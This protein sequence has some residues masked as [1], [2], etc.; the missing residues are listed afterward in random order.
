MYLERFDYQDRV[1]G[2]CHPWRTQSDPML[3]L[4]AYFSVVAQN[5]RMP[6]SSALRGM[7]V[8][9]QGKQHHFQI[10]YIS[11]SNEAA[12]SLKRAWELTRVCPPAESP[13]LR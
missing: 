13:R 1:R 10:C 2:P 9:T 3:A 4:V 7:K 12:V 11:H 8:P 5:T 6:N